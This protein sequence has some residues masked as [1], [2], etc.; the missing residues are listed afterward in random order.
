[1]DN[2]IQELAEKIY[3]DGISKANEEAE[4]IAE[5]ARSHSDD[6]IAEARAE[7]EKIISNAKAEAAQLRKQSET[8][9]K[10][11]TLNAEDLLQAKVTE[12]INSAAVN[13]AVDEVFRDPQTL[14][15]VVLE[16]SRQMFASDT[17]GVTISTSDAHALEEYFRNE[18]KDVLDKGVKIREVAG[19]PAMFD[20]APD[21]ADYKIN[22]SKE[23]FAEYFKEFMRPRM[24]SILFGDKEA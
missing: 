7:A 18:A 13:K 17:Q 20:I 2:K 14:Y 16:M 10:N 5:K 21:G 8:D 11:M 1:M 24:R 22:V 19:K 3:Q 4:Q 12:M 9:V 23:A 6:M 15:K